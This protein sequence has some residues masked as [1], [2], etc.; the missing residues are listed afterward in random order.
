MFAVLG[1]ELDQAHSENLVHPY[2]PSNNQ[3][4][5]WPNLKDAGKH[6]HE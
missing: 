1:H 4:H 6:L 2:T 5:A 3:Q